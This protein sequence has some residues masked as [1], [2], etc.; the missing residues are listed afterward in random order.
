MGSWS[1]PLYYIHRIFM[2]IIS[3]KVKND[4]KVVQ[5]GI[6]LSVSGGSCALQTPCCYGYTILETPLKFF[7]LRSCCARG[8]QFCHQLNQYHISR[9]VLQ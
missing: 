2:N 1:D 7:C 6:Y 4:K 8:H 9:Y 3:L 5:N